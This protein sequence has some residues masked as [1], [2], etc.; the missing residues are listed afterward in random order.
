VALARPPDTEDLHDIVVPYNEQRPIGSAPA[1]WLCPI[2]DRRRLDSSR[3]GMLHGFSLG[4]YLLLVDYTGRLFL[5]SA[6]DVAPQTIK[7]AAEVLL[8]IRTRQ[9][10]DRDS[11]DGGIISGADVIVIQI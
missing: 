1:W 6:F 8:G 9:R 3:E 7:S 10:P 5:I 11:R 4:S 2:E